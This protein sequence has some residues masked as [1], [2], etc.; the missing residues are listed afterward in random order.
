MR[1]RILPVVA[2]LVLA[3]VAGI[4]VAASPG[5]LVRTDYSH[6]L[7]DDPIL[8]PGQP[9]A[10]HLHDFLCN[11]STNAN[12][13]FASMQAAATNCQI[14]AEKAG[15][16]APA[17]YQNGVKVNP[18]GVSTRQQNYYRDNNLTVG[19]PVEPFPSD[20]RMIAGNA[21][22]TSEATNPKLGSELYWGCSDNSV[23]GK[24]KAPPASCPTGIISLH[25]GFPNCWNG[26][27]DPTNDTPNLKYPSGGVCPAGFT[28]KLPRYILRLEYPVGTTTGTITLSSGPYY[29]VHADYWFVWDEVRFNELVQNCL[30]ADVDCGTNP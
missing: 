3:F 5:W 29:T 15:I 4:A 26:V 9:G 20:F 23:P 12:S 7:N 17:L 27:K 25:V 30:N 19:T 16:W 6:S 1:R 13:T 22:A 10:S 24:P 14:A 28:R 11:T 2:F 21:N 8:L 18:T